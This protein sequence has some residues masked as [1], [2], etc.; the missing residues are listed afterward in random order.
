MPQI[1]I[2]TVPK[3]FVDNSAIG[4]SKE[5]FTFVLIAGTNGTVF[6]LT[7]EHAKRFHLALKYH[8]EKFERESRKVEADW[9]PNMPSPIQ[10]PDLNNGGLKK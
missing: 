6:A 1:N 5:F 8:L 4:S 2:D 9:N 3:Q 10:P 7:P